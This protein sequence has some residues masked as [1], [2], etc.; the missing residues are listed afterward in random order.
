M[1]VGSLLVELL[2]VFEETQNPRASDTRAT[3]YRW[4]GMIEVVALVCGVVWFLQERLCRVLELPFRSDAEV[5]IEEGP[6]YFRFKA[7]TEGISDV[8]A[9]TVEIHPGVIKIMVRESGSVE[10]SLDE[11]ELDMWRFVV[12]IDGGARKRDSV[13]G[14]L[15]VTVSKGEEL[16]N[17]EDGNG[18]GGGEMWGDGNGMGGRLVLVQ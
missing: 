3:C 13:D 15:I 6:D 8:K 1:K 9:N 16:D 5:S 11:I 10:L 17:S 2:G 7:E 14:E 18:N 12:G 4:K